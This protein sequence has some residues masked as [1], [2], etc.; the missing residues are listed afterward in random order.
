[1]VTKYVS[2]VLVTPASQPPTS[3]L[4]TR[5]TLSISRTRPMR[6]SNVVLSPVSSKT[7]S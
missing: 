1:M 7:V 4:L 6:C 5:A 3:E 2:R